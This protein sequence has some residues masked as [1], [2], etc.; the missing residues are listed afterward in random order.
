MSVSAA[1]SARGCHRRHLRALRARVPHPSGLPRGRSDWS[2]VLG[3]LHPGGGGPDGHCAFLT[4]TGGSG[5]AGIGVMLR[6]GLAWSEG[7]A[8]GAAPPCAAPDFPASSRRPWPVWVS[9]WEGLNGRYFQVSGF[10]PV[11][12]TSSAR[13]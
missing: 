4:R 2:G 8:H 1:R 7:G 5:G 10:F 6:E 13:S 12:E 11:G 9:S 3:A